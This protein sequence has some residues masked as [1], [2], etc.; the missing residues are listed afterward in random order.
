MAT[1]IVSTPS[2]EYKEMAKKW[3]M[4]DNLLGGTQTM[5]AARETW[6]PKFEKEKMTNYEKRLASS[7]LYNGL[8]NAIR[9]VVS[10]PFSKPVII[11]GTI[12][13]RLEPLRRDADL[14][15]RSF[16]QFFRQ[17]FFNAVSY[18]LTHNFVDFTRMQG[19]E[20]KAEEEAVGARAR[21]VQVTPQQLIGWRTDDQGLSEIR[22]TETKIEPKGTYLDE[23]VNYVRYYTR[24]V[25]EFY[26]QSEKD[27]NEYTLVDSGNHTFGR[28]P[29]TTLYLN[30]TGF[31]T[32]EPPFEDLAW[33]NIAHWQS[34]SDQ[35]NILK[36]ARTGLLLLAGITKDEFKEKVVIGPNQYV[37]ADD[38]QAKGEYIEQKGNAI[39]EG[40]RDLEKLEERMVVLG[41]QPFVDKVMTATE[42]VTH[43]TRAD[44]D[45]QSW[46]RGLEDF[47]LDSISIAAEWT[48]DELAEDVAVDVTNDF[49][50]TV[51]GKEDIRNLIAARE[52]REISRRTFLRELK[53]RGLLSEDLDIEEEMEEIDSEQED[54]DTLNLALNESDDA[55]E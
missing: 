21:F 37:R 18:G 4:I 46:V 15:G 26:K 48:N 30:R 17:A 3:P 2:I 44:S 33:M 13:D 32:G 9:N 47:A 28:I 5:R 35:R 51:R 7:F 52:K 23:A 25:W 42:A 1:D 24:D 11:E 53:R 54:L 22:F 41:L 49:G 12:P 38:P 19:D 55:D 36:F 27:P 50:I 6:L 29:L 20:T 8:K 10:K 16:T 45:V 43:E 40:W 34:S 31:L 14:N 39:G